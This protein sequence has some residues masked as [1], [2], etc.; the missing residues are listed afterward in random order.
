LQIKE[1]EE[2]ISYI[3]DL[4]SSKQ[5]DA[6]DFR[7]MKTEYSAKLEKLEDKFSTCNHDHVD[8]KDLLDKGINN[9]LKLDNLF[10]TA[11]IE[12]KRE[13]VSSMYS[14]KMTF[15]GF[16]FRTSRINEI[17]R[18]IYSLDEDYSENKNRANGNNSNLSCQVGAAERT[19]GF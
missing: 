17:A 12:M 9:L 11:D 14:E 8:I 16:S 7:E 5:I 1:L 3:R 10:E 2:K 19:N 4:L 6:S 15:N 18:M 13:I